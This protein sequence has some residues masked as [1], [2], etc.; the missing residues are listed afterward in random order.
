MENR[1][2]ETLSENLKRLIAIIEGD[3]SLEAIASAQKSFTSAVE[4]AMKKY[5]EG[6]IEVQ[7]RG[8]PADMHIFATRDLPKIIEDEGQW[9]KILKDLKRF[10]RVME[11]VVEPKEGD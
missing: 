7:V 9:P 8:L 11:L 1:T 4:E 5:N 3:A 2:I 10:E 6:K